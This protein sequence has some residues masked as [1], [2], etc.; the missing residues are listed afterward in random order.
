MVIEREETLKH[1]ARQAA[2]QAKKTRRVVALD[3]MSPYERRIIHLEL[4]NDQD[5]E[6]KSDGEPPYRSVKVYSKRKGGYNKRYN[7]RGGYH[8]S[9][10]YK[11][12]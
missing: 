2:Q 1:I 11:N 12:R 8:K 4:Q 6:T 5:V 10:Y 7:D 9:S 3:P